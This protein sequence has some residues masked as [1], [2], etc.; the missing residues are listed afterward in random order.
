MYAQGYTNIDYCYQVAKSAL[1][2]KQNFAT[3]NSSFRTWGYNKDKSNGYTGSQSNYDWRGVKKI[4]PYVDFQLYENQ[5]EWSVDENDNF[6]CHW[7]TVD[8]SDGIWMEKGRN[9]IL[10]FPAKKEHANWDYWTGKM[11]IFEGLGEETIQGSNAHAT[12]KESAAPSAAGKA[13][14]LGNTTLAEMSVQNEQLYYYDEESGMFLSE[15][16]AEVKIQPAQGFLYVNPKVDQEA[17][18]EV[19][20]IEAY[21]GKCWYFLTYQ[22]N[23]ISVERSAEKKTYKGLD[24]NADGTENNRYIYRNEAWVEMTDEDGDHAW[25]GSNGNTYIYYAD[26]WVIVNKVSGLYTDGVNTYYYDE[27]SDKWVILT[28]NCGIYSYDD[29]TFMLINNVLTPVT[30]NANDPAY[31][32]DGSNPAQFYLAPNS[33]CAWIAVNVNN[34]GAYYYGESPYHF[35]I[36]LNDA[37]VAV[38]RVM[39]NTNWNHTYTDNA[40]NYYIRNNDNWLIINGPDENHLYHGSDIKTYIYYGNPADWVAVTHH[41]DAIYTDSEKYYQY[42]TTSS[43]WEVVEVDIV[44]ET[45]EN[46][47][48]VGHQSL[49]DLTIKANGSVTIPSETSLTVQNLIIEATPD[50]N[51]SGIING[52]GMANLTV[53]GDAYVDITM[54]STGEMD[55]T[56]YYSF[57]VP[58]AVN[59][60]DGV[61]RLNKNNGL[62]ETATFGANYLAYEYDE[63]ERAAHGPSNACW[64]KV[65]SGQYVPGKFYLCEFDNDNYNVY[66]FKASDKSQLNAIANISVSKSSGDAPNAGW[67]GVS[68][69]GISYSRL[70]GSFGFMFALNSVANAFDIQLANEASLAVGRAVFVQV[71]EAGIVTIN[72]TSPSSAPARARQE[73]NSINCLRITENGK[74]K[75]DDQLFFSASE[76]AQPVYVAGK[77]IEK[78]WMGTPSVA[79]IWAV[80]YNG[81]RLAANDAVLVDE[82]VDYQLGISAP[83]NGEYVLALQESDEAVTVY[84]T[85]NGTIIANLTLGEYPI[86]LEKGET[87]EYGLRIIVHKAP[88]VATDFDAAIVDNPDGVHKVIINDMMYIIKNKHVYTT[89]GQIVK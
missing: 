32:V 61:Q 9:Y 70:N 34:D 27:T 55:A 4:T 52:A 1:Y 51:Q 56:K 69:M 82:R 42:N 20:G 49:H 54:N 80:D 68:G 46:Y 62:W 77:D 87:A 25:A 47:S 72:Q 63:A 28:I 86:S 6:T 23:E 35:Y 8:N 24:S 22:E 58:F 74:Q 2:T 41:E 76:E 15:P 89:N 84:L 88:N 65:T 26:A 21:T 14:M 29:H 31:R 16:E 19:F 33:S 79:R 37:W 48:V 85:Q 81:L 18:V 11:I 75:Y 59:R 83:K 73:E 43:K 39:N 45:G 30:L 10:Q 40:G 3:I 13:V 12:I 78:M 53:V 7:G 17:P 67:N 36:Y 71:T 57:A 50:N 5:Q 44:V 66:R 64:K 38:D 60:A